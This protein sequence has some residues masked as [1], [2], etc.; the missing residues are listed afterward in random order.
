MTIEKAISLYDEARKNNKFSRS[1]KVDRYVPFNGGYILFPVRGS[2]ETLGDCWY[3]VSSDGKTME[4]PPAM[5][6]SN[7]NDSDV[8]QI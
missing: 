2:V 7:F 4:I 1:R 5:V 8:K 6:V 3:Y